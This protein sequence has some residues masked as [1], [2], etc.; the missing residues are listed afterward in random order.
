MKA[1][2]GLRE[3]KD[4]QR[5]S[6]KVSNQLDLTKVALE[7]SCM[8]NE[9]RMSSELMTVTG[10]PIQAA[11]C[12][13]HIKKLPFKVQNYHQQIGQLSGAG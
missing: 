10:P 5:M 12:V 4:I 3:Q 13:L 7:L 1:T 11:M 6:N 2:I 9:N 8:R